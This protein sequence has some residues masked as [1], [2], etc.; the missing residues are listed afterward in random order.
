MM[1]AFGV[2]GIRI[3]RNSIYVP[4]QG[5]YKSPGAY[6]VEADASS[7]SYLLAAA[8]IKGH[9][10]IE[11]LGKSSIQGEIKFC[12]ALKRM[13]AAIDVKRSSIICRAG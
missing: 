12:Q 5:G 11:R 4:P 2:S 1:E 8:A 6:Y 9:V 13:G 10:Q 3:K 7:A